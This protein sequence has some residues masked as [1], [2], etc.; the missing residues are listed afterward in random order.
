MS[1][2]TEKEVV[3]EYPID[4]VYNTLINL[5]PIKSYRLKESD[6]TAHT[7]R[8]KSITNFQFKMFITLTPKTPQTTLINLT[9][10]FTGAVVDLWGGGKRGI[11][12]VLEAL[13]KE[14]D[15]QPKAEV[16]VNDEFKYCISCGSENL[17]IAKYCEICGEKF[18]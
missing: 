16:Q 13:L 10:D 4:T 6:E 5:F 2:K 3:V 12:T 1:A 18:I 8:V 9:T 11:N 7:M 15:K 17:N 14:L